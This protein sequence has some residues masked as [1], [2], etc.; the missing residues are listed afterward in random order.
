MSNDW[1]SGYTPDVTGKVVLVTGANSGLGLEVTR[2]LATNGARVLMACRNQEKAERAAESVR[3]SDPKGEVAV[4]SL[5]LASLESV[6]D[7]AADTRDTE[8]HID[9]LVNNAGL[10]ATDELRTA[11]GF[12]M[13]IGV[14]HFGHFALTAQLLPLLL[15]SPTSRVVTV[16]S[17]GHRMG[18]M[19]FDDLMFERHRYS[20]WPA[21]FQSKLANL[22]FS[23]ELQRRLERSGA[24]T[25]ALA[26]HPGSTSTDL[27]TEG[28]GFTNRLIEPLFPLAGQAVEGGALPILRAATDPA[29]RGG[30]YYGPRWLMSGRPVRETPSRRARSTADAARLWTIS[31]ALTHTTV[32]L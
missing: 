7:F 16:S 28:T 11:D 26:A 12:E 15:A 23:A 10:M 9:L 20:R 6:R 27:G 25:V 13:Q 5:D 17:F 24:T 14:N 29:A 1:P 31:E 22:L 19:H 3:A 4:R 21:Y 32:D 18:R 2:V 30:E 8:D